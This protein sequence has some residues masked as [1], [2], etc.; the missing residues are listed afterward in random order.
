MLTLY[1][2]STHIATKYFD[3]YFSLT[4]CNMAGRYFFEYK[5]TQIGM[6]SIVR[7]NVA[8]RVKRTRFG[9]YERTD[10]L[11]KATSKPAFSFLNRQL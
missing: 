6:I 4:M 9:K 1:N 3:T 5:E 7:F 2:I 11:R 8:F 10:S